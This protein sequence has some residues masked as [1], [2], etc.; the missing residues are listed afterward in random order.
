M[1]FRLL[2]PIELVDDDGL[3]VRLPAGKP[4]A[5]LA[6]LLLEAGR[7]VSVD[8]IVDVLW[9]E[10]PPATAA[11]IVQGY[12]SR[13][14]KLLPAGVLETRE[15]GYVL[16]VE[17]NELDLSR[18]ERLR[19]DAAAAADDGRSQAAATLLAEALALWRGRPLA[20]V[21]DELELPG[22]LARLDE[23]RLATLE[24]RIAVDLGLGRESQ[25][26][27][28]L[29]ALTK[30]H[31]LRERLRAQ[32]ML[33]LYRLGR[34]A[35][36]LAAYRDTRQ[37][38]VEELG[39]EPSAEL[40][41]L[42]RQILTQDETLP[43]TVRTE[44]LP[45]VPAA[46][47]RLIGRRSEVDEIGELLGRTGTRLVTLVGPGGVGKTRLALT[48]AEQRADAAYVSL[49]PVQEPGL[50][51][52]VVAHTLG[53]AD[54]GSLA[55]WLRPR[56]L[57]LVLDNFEHLLDAAPF[58]TEL[59][60]A[61]RGLSVLA[62]SRTPL[63]VSGEHV[64][65]VSPLPERDAVDLFVERAAAAGAA[66]EGV[67]AVEEICRRLDCLPLAIE[68]AAA[69]VTT[70]S[71]ELLLGRLAERL[72]ILTRGPRDLPERQRTLRATIE[73][74]YALL[75]REEQKGFA[76]LAVFAGGSTLEAAEQVCDARLET[77]DSLV[78]KS[79][80][81]RSGERFTM[82]ETIREYAGEQLEACGEAE[83]IA[84]RLTEWLCE[85][86]EA[87]AEQWRDRGDI[88]LVS[89]L[90]SELENVRVAI[91]WALGWTDDPLALRLT[92]ALAGFWRAS[93]RQAEGLR[94]TVEALEHFEHAPAAARAEG[95]HAAAVLATLAADS[96]RGRTFGEE[97]LALHRAAGDA[98]RVGEVLPWLANAH[99]QAGEADRARSLHAESIALQE[100]LGDPT[101]FARA[102]RWAA[103][104]ELEL[105][106]ATRAID[107]FERALELARVADVQSEVAATLHG[108]GD[109]A[110]VRRDAATA[111]S[112]YLE[113]L[114]SSVDPTP[115]AYFLAGLAAVAA[116]DQLVDPAGRMWGAVES[117]RQRLGEF[118]L[119]QTLRRYETVFNQLETGAFADAVAVGRKL[120]L[121]QAKREAIEA[122]A[123]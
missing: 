22:E 35:D 34:Q 121:E 17:D 123:M 44:R 71:P 33:A 69:R 25:L 49:A 119:P 78:A 38:L 82:L 72:A 24:E 27:P 106:N 6:I 39:I 55:E 48:V 111:A 31:P 57:L 81:Q 68:L 10:R 52:S 1:E 77:L 90:E 85:I 120:T 80:L 88:S 21:A 5:L 63:N 60:A 104:D 79:L 96:L 3:P 20:D 112:F 59:L 99:Q 101:Q 89:R 43:A 74:S 4:R 94:W 53:L 64:Y 37:L 54:E 76:R 15:P 18:F 100:R 95:L 98:H 42:E 14:R 28:E 51:R 66:V 117:H 118:I 83:P 114:R 46:L 97:A 58:V 47:T 13:L 103:D 8:R 92:A 65:T 50:V 56:E 32:L 108:L 107:L 2:G 116:L 30:A 84:R 102:L 40:Q 9:S 105:G 70:L 115:M 45:P 73:W 93:G 67:A 29:E 87:F 11:K 19:A 23:L 91:R 7:V 36:A 16:R 62:T 61:A 75:E 110:L 26:V 41:Q 122:F 86:A 113:G 12:V 109:L